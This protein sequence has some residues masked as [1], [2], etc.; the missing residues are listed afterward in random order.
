MIRAHD[1]NLTIAATT[2]DDDYSSL[3]RI[4]NTDIKLGSITQTART[5]SISSRPG[6]ATRRRVSEVSA[7]SIESALSAL[8]SKTARSINDEEEMDLG[9][10]L[11]DLS[12]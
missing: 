10:M 6:A 1:K 7:A 9:A 8:S 12:V 3:E 4:V 5:R 11:K 2:N